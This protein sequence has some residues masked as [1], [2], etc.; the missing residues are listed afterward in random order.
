MIIFVIFEIINKECVSNKTFN[1]LI[2]IG[3]LQIPWEDVKILH[4]YWYFCGNKEDIVMKLSG[5][6]IAILWFKEL[7][8]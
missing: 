1:F 5:L 6:K 2:I 8:Y 7:I 3:T 4:K